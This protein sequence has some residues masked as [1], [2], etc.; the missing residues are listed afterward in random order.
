MIDSSPGQAAARPVRQHRPAPGHMAGPALAHGRRP[1]SGPPGDLGAAGPAR[2][3]RR[4]GLYRGAIGSCPAQFFL[5]LRRN[6]SGPAA[7]V[8]QYLK[9]SREPGDGLHGSSMEYG[10]CA[11]WLRR[12]LFAAVM[13]SV[14]VPLA[15][16]LASAQSDGV[17]V[18]AGSPSSPVPQNKQNEPAVAIDPLNPKI[19]VAG[20]NDEIDLAPCAGSSCPFTPGV[21]LSGVYFSTS[22]GASWSQPTYSGLP[23]SAGQHKWVP[24][25]LLTC[26][27]WVAGVRQCAPC[28]R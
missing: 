14:I 19:A 26:L 8:S 27:G 18:S 1:C 2:Q 28:P 12:G 22:G 20:A 13:A 17:L 11:M 5:V 21:G 10:V 16:S 6:I 25:E 4:R 24:D 15:P 23:V 3:A 7:R 9:G